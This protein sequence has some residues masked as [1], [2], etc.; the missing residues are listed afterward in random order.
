MKGILIGLTLCF[1]L[2]LASPGFAE[3]QGQGKQNAAE[4]A[5]DAVNKVTPAAAKSMP[6]VS[7]EKSE[8][9]ADDAAA[10]AKKD[11]AKA[12]EKKVDDEMKKAADA[13][14]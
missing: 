9:A 11:A 1:A 12:S 8:A 7:A 2:V 4:P 5:Q 6:P 14:E 13:V 10:S 3:S